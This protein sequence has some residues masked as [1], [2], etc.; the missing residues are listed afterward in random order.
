MGGRTRLFPKILIKELLKYQWY[1]YANKICNWRVTISVLNCYYMIAALEGNMVQ[2]GAQQEPAKA[3]TSYTMTTMQSNVLDDTIYIL[4][5][6][7]K[8]VVMQINSY[9]IL[10]MWRLLTLTPGMMRPDRSRSELFG[11]NNFREGGNVIYKFAYMC[12]CVSFSRISLYNQNIEDKQQLT[13]PRHRETAP[14]R[15]EDFQTTVSYNEEQRK[16]QNA[17]A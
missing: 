4:Q 11:V 9:Q 5:R 17:L 8:I 15:I 16:M 1:M 2:N 3:L 7:L 10:S 13:I 14:I 6:K 12:L